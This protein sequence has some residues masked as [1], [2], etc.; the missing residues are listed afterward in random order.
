[1]LFRGREV[2]ENRGTQVP[3][4][5]SLHIQGKKKVCSAVQNGTVSGFIFYEQ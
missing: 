5:V 1:M 3:S 4:P 2:G